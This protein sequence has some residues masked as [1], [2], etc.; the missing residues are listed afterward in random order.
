MAEDR[1]YKWMGQLIYAQRIAIDAANEVVD[2]LAESSPLIEIVEEQ[3]DEMINL[4]EILQEFLDESVKP[5]IGL[6]EEVP[7][8]V[9]EKDRS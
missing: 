5:L 1:L 9:D 7:F 8:S 6:D 2:A 3:A 4:N